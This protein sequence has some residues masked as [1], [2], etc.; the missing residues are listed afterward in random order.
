[1]AQL[2]KM[3]AV[4]ALVL[5]SAACGR[6]QKDAGNAITV[7]GSDTMV[8]LVADWAEAYMA[9]HPDAEVSVNG[10]GSGTGIKA[11]INGTTDIA[12]ASRDMSAEERAQ[13]AKSGREPKEIE[14]A[15]DGIA[16]IV[17]PKNPI[18]ELTLD[19]LK[20]IYTGAYTRWSDVG[21][22][23]ETIGVL[24]RE[25][26]SGTYVFFQEH[27]LEKQ[28]YAAHVR[29]MP[30]TAGIIQT[31]SEDLWAIGYVGLG[32]AAG[33]GDKVK[34]VKV[35]A[36]DDAPA[37]APSEE[38]VKSGE[39]S[40]ARGLFLYVATD[41]SPVVQRFIDFVLGEAGQE[42]VRKDDYIT[43]R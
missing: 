43:V 26:S 20:K 16:V 33:A 22:S 40:I 41:T 7:K 35:K 1:M 2:V 36:K 3:S 38:T 24:S 29:L 11:F 31:V 13:A 34:V 21:G 37:V 28:D 39:Y 14:V 17:N 9:A 6:P 27:V 32:Y 4:V 23:D 19:Q 15:L 5:V 25:S 12:A 42:I 30:A 10:G 18:G 8:H